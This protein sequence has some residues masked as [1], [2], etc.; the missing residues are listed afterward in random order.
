MGDGRA[1][2]GAAAREDDPNKPGK[3]RSAEGFAILRG[4][5][6]GEHAK[7]GDK[8]KENF[9]KGVPKSE[10]KEVLANILIKEYGAAKR[11]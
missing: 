11:K 10:L 6:V 8:D 5:T 9:P 2:R 3:Q 4:G 1:H 7:L